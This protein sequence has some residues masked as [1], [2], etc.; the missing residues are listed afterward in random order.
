MI[1]AALILPAVLA[2]ICI[3]L[4]RRTRLVEAVSVA[5]AGSMLVLGLYL[6][7]RVFDQGSLDEGIWYMDQFSGLMML[8]IVLIGS[9]AM[10]YSVPYMRHELD[11]GEVNPKKVAYYYGFLF[12]FIFTMVLV[13]VSDNLGMVW[14]A[15]E[16]TTLVSAFLVGF[17]NKATSLEATWKYLIICSIGISLALLGTIFIYASS[18]PILGEGSDLHWTS[19]M[20]VADQLDPAFLKIGF[21]L[22]LIGYGTKAGL[23]PMHTWLP[24]AHSQSPSPVSALLSGVLLNCAMYAVLRYHVLL[25]HSQLGGGFSSGLLLLFGLLS[26]GIAAAFIITQKD[27]KRLLAYSSIEHMGIISIGFGFGG[28]W[29]IFGG[30][31]HMLN[32]SLTKALLFFGAGNVLQKYGT[33]NI[34]EVRG[35]VR[36]MPFTAALLMLGALAITGSPPFSI[37]TSEIMVLTAGIDQGNILPAISYSLML[38][39]VFAA[40]MG[41]IVKMVFGEPPQGMEKGEISKMGLVPMIALAVM[42]TIMGLFIPDVLADALRDIIALFGGLA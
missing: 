11:S 15:V 34:S 10:V 6:V 5:G 12:L 26:L 9:L 42:I 23:A 39:V 3:L 18:L 16:A 41:H 14:I 22:V 2:A 4:G 30:L 27:Y 20:A 17:H 32:H 8:I 31:L 21:V 36:T 7:F 1:E 19:L 38:V 29:G 35:L 37:F 13:V 24:D 33:K 25:T 40:F 28:Y